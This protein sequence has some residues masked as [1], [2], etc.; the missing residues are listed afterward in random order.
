MI[1][2]KDNLD[3]IKA[4]I[5][6]ACQQSGRLIPYTEQVKQSLPVSLLAVSKTK[7]AALIEQAYLAG[8][9]D[10]GENYLQEAVEKI[11]QLAHL[12]E[13]NWHFIGPIQANKTKQIARYFSWVH[14]VDREKIARRLNQHIQDD[15]CHNTPL[16]ICLQVNISNEESKSGVAIDDILSL[17][18][19]VNN[20]DKLT[21][22]GL[23]AVPEKNAGNDCYEK[24]QQLFIQLQKHYPSVDTLS[25]GMSNDLPQAVAHGSTMVRIGSAIFGARTYKN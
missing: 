7:P 14:S 2:I 25:L 11:T 21:L 3:K 6:Q 23:M 8:Q 18:D 1:N 9:H 22:R 16:N 13:L 19:I 15:N 24:M 20:C 10:F 17:A 4:Q 5:Q 12:P